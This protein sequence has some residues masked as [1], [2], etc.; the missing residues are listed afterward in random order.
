MRFSLCVDKDLA[1]PDYV[2]LARAAEVGGL[3][4]PWV[5]ETVVRSKSLC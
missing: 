2:A 4:P 3:D 1:I 5:S